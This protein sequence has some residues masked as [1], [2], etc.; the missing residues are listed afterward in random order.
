MSDFTRALPF[1][2]AGAVIAAGVRHRR[3]PNIP[4]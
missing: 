4:S 3:T 1:I 2:A